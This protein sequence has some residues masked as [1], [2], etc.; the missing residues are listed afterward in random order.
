VAGAVSTLTELVCPA[1]RQ[2]CCQKRELVIVIVAHRP[3]L[4][5]GVF[6]HLASLTALILAGRVGIRVGSSGLD[7]V[8]SGR[9]PQASGAT[10]S[11][12]R[13]GRPQR[14][15]CPGQCDCL[16]SVRLES[17]LHKRAVAQTPPI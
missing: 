6:F 9:L 14:P 10:A 13:W 7:P 2:G 12:S 17:V 1:E 15:R 8:V 11:C 3:C 5:V 16:D 4:S